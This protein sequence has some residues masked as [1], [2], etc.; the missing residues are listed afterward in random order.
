[1]IQGIRGWLLLTI[2]ANFHS[3]PQGRSTGT[4]LPDP[5]SGINTAG[6]QADTQTRRNFE[7]M[8]SAESRKAMRGSTRRLKRDDDPFSVGVGLGSIDVTYGVH[9]TKHNVNV[10][11]NVNGLPGLPA[12][13]AWSQWSAC[14]GSTSRWMGIISISISSCEPPLS[15]LTTHSLTKLPTAILPSR[16]PRGRH[17]A[18]PTTILSMTEHDARCIQPPRLHV[19]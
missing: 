1:M 7:T 5:D 14:L 11:V 19:K 17:T 18:R 15:H 12:W 3:A 9:N 8:T 13:P 4:F 16:R 6:K 2:C 10:N